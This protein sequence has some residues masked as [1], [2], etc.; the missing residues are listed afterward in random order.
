MNEMV[1][2]EFIIKQQFSI[3]NHSM[4]PVKNMAMEISMPK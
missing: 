3:F 4:P 1:K 2:N